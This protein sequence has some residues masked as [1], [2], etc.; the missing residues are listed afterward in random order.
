MKNQVIAGNVITG[1]YD[2]NI[3]EQMIFTLPYD[4]GWKAYVNDSPVEIRTW[5]NGLMAIDLPAGYSAIR[6]VY[7]PA[8]LKEGVELSLGGLGASVLVLGV[9]ALF[10]WRKK[11]KNESE[12]EE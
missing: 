7:E 2:S 8:G 1:D 4:A 9:P 12:N 6:L 11:K 10:A 5:Q 3:P